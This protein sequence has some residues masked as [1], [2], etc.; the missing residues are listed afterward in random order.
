MKNLN[1]ATLFL[2]LIL[3]FSFISCDN[4][5]L[6]PALVTQ[7]TTPGTGGGSGGNGGGGGTGPEVQTGQFTATV[8]GQ[9]F[10]SDSSV[11][12]YITVNGTN[13]LTIS[14]IKTTG[15]YIAIQI[16][17]PAIGS[18][19]INSLTGNQVISYRQNATTTDIYSA[20]NYTTGQPT[21]V[22]IINSL[23]FT[24]KKIS[25]TFSFDGYL[26]NNP[27]LTKQITNGIFTDVSFI[28]STVTNP[29]VNPTIA[30][31]YLLTAFNTSVPTDLNGDG[32]SSINQMN[33]T[34]CLN[35]S[36]LTLNSNNTFTANGAS[37]DIDLTITPNTI[38]CENDPAFTGTWS[39][40]GNL[41]TVT[42]VESGITYTDVFTSSGNT[43]VIT[44]QNGQV[45]GTANGSPVFLT[46][47]ISAVYTKQ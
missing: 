21:G 30:G 19:V 36:L 5:P 47:D 25:G 33:E 4:E 26:L 11:G 39:L 10:I 37:I 14:G 7:L 29:P 41:L 45:V 9:N 20:T 38:T 43:L 27:A 18:Y 22:L 31:T 40:A 35:N 28:D 44:E 8:A 16:K 17:N 46:A 42:Y 1:L 2:F 24:T 12:N 23:N 32:T 6:D 3:S 34:T 15:E 13:V